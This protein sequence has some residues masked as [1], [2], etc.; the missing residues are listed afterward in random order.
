[1]EAFQCPYLGR[2]VELNDERERHIAEK[3]SPR[4]NIPHCSRIGL[5]VSPRLWLTRI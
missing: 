2:L 5:I 1:M 3:H 4:K